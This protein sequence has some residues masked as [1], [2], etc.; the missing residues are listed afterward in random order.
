MLKVVFSDS[1]DETE[2]IPFNSRNKKRKFPVQESTKSEKLYDGTNDLFLDSSSD[3]D[4]VLPI[5]SEVKVKVEEKVGIDEDVASL[6]P[7]GKISKSDDE[8]EFDSDVEEIKFKRK[9]ENELEEPST[10]KMK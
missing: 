7:S 4:T 5:K 2:E 8:I 9:A 1:E 10:K 3:E 6:D